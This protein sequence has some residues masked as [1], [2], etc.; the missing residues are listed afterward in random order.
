MALQYCFQKNNRF[1][2]PCFF[3]LGCVNDENSRRH[4][5]I[6]LNWILQAYPFLPLVLLHSARQDLV[7]KPILDAPVKNIIS[8]HEIWNKIFPEIKFF[9]TEQPF[10]GELRRVLNW[11]RKIVFSQSDSNGNCAIIRAKRTIKFYCSSKS[12]RWLHHFFFVDGQQKSTP[13]L[14]CS[15]LKN[16]SKDS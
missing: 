6:A 2:F 10:L 14:A 3:C 13:Y 5:P 16:G 11:W 8:V 7:F 1:C 9:F 12:I 15:S 4:Y